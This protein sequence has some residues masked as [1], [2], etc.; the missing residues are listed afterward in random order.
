MLRQD[1]CLY[2]F[3]KLK[4]VCFEIKRSIVNIWRCQISELPANNGLADRRLSGCAGLTKGD[5]CNSSME[6]TTINV[7]DND[8]KKNN[9]SV[10]SLYH[11][12]LL[13]IV[14]CGV[15]FSI[16]ETTKNFVVFCRIICSIPHGLSFCFHL[17]SRFVTLH[18]RL[19]R[20]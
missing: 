19:K 2:I 14:Y 6:L 20:S 1:W 16:M 12:H 17:L 18:E 9:N 10:P 3:Y 5:T 11:H 15:F 13:E 8:V 7:N 4:N